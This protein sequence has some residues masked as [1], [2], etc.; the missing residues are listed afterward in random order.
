MTDLWHIGLAVPELDEGMRTVGE[1]FDLTWR[2]VHERTATVT[3]E[4]GAHH[5][6]V[7]RFTFSDGGPFA[8]EMWQAIPGTPLATPETGILHHIGYWVEDLAKEVDR[9]E[10]LGFGSFMSGPSLAIHRG[11]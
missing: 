10:G 9:L 7:C 6:I 5:D 11:P 1:A 3:D 2:P 8:I 4:S